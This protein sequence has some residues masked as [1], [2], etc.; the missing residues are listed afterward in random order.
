MNTCWVI[1]FTGKK[2]KLNGHMIELLG[3][4][5]T[6]FKAKQNAAC[7]LKIVKLTGH[8]HSCLYL[9]INML[10]S[11]LASDKICSTAL[12]RCCSQPK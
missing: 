4:H 2:K 11:V 8:H 1:K 5:S 10:I 9:W 7:I 3:F 6:S 12:M